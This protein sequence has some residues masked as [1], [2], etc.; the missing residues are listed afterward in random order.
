[1]L[2][3][4]RRLLLIVCA[5]ALVAGST[6]SFAASPASANEPCAD[7]H[8]HGVGSQHS[9]HHPNGCLSCC[10]LGS[11]VAFPSLPPRTLAENV[12][13]NA[14]PVMYW[15]AAVPLSGRSVTPE[16]TPPKLAS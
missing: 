4:V 12:R 8:H 5:L 10:S 13:F 11:C 9:D 14:M 1:M 3:F 16:P 6:I 15:D 7:Q 2:R